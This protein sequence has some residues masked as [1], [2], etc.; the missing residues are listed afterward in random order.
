M[1]CTNRRACM[2]TTALRDLQLPAAQV[3]AVTGH[4]SEL[5]MRRDYHVMQILGHDNDV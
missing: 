4:R 5:Q 3:M 1:D 2:V